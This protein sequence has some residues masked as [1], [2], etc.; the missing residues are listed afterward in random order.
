METPF[1]FAE[2]RPGCGR[3]GAQ[4]PDPARSGHRAAARGGGRSRQASRA[5]AAVRGVRRGRGWRAAIA[6]VIFPSRRMTT[7]RSSRS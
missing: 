6:A 1:E 2:A 5:R 7:S 4:Q 3:G